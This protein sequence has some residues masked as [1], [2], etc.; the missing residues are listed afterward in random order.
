MSAYSPVNFRGLCLLYCPDTTDN[1]VAPP[2]LIKMGLCDA[3]TAYY[4]GQTPPQTLKPSAHSPKQAG[5][6][7]T[8]KHLQ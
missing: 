2:Q 7:A 6:E 3:D 8:F 5:L 1:I 4:D